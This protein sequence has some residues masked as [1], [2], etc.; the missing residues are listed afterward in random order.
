MNLLIL[1]AATILLA[2]LLAAEKRESLKGKLLTKPLASLL[3]ILLAVI[4]PHPLPVYYHWML[5][6]L[7]FCL[8]GDVCL[9]LP[10][11]PAFTAGLVA[12]L[13]G[14]IMYV[15]AFAQISPLR[16]WLSAGA[17]CVV[18]VSVGAFI[19]LRPHLGKMTGPVLAYILI[20]SLML[21]GAVGVVRSGGLRP[22]GQW[23]VFAGALFFYV[24]DLF[25]AR[26][27]FVTQVYANRA[28]GL[29][30]YYAGQFML[31]FSTGAVF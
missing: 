3:F 27:R 16:L 25:V 13:M 23:L 26:Q 17:I 8:V 7:V 24:S 28:L 5:A 6:G 12:F 15:V 29:P 10:H 22:E 14:H 20:I 9:A 19:W 1:L 31:A 2:G 4:Q 11:R 18:A 21:I 30:L